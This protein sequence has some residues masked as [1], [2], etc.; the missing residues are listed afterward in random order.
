MS[1]FQSIQQRG[2]T[3]LL[4]STLFALSVLT[5]C[6]STGSRPDPT[7][8]SPVPQQTAWGAAGW[9]A[10][11]G[12]WAASVQPGVVD[13]A[14][15][16]AT[17]GGTVAVVDARGG[18]RWRVDVGTELTTMPGFDGR[19][20]A[21]IGKN[22]ELIVSEAGRVLWRQKLGVQT[23]TTPL[24][25]G[26]RV[27]VLAGDRKVMA[28]D[29]A[30]GAPLWKR[31]RIQETLVLQYPVLLSAYRNFLLMGLSGDL[32]AYNP[33]TGTEQWY[34]GMAKS[35][36]TNEIEQ[37]VDLVGKHFRDGDVLCARSFQTA[38][39]CADMKEHRLLWTKSANGLHGVDGNA[40]HIF[41]VDANGMVMARQRADGEVAWLNNRLLFRALS[42]PTV[43][44]NLLA[45][46]DGEGFVHFV[47][48]ETGRLTGRVQTGS[49]VSIS[50][51]AVGDTLLVLT[52]DGGIRA[53]R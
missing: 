18:E 24:V 22:N 7:P 49:G 36:S 11:Y 30:G 41:A 1:M 9:S 15:A 40:Q 3:A 31:Q 44:G 16:V 20:A 38:V 12:E 14:V 53:F 34:V 26:N 37:L 2:R 46:G 39:S 27:F 47:S 52:D 43:I 25:A 5:A 21:V 51:I 29:A 17:R 48:A 19:W 8:L 32:V 13:G 35:R 4:A 6:S 50:P 33:D 28:F 42:A 23:Y 45:V 10:N